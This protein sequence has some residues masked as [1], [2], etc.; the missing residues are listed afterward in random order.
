MPNNALNPS[1]QKNS[2]VPSNATDEQP[3]PTTKGPASQ[4]SSV[5]SM[6][7][8][9]IRG[10]SIAQPIAPKPAMEKEMDHFAGEQ[11]SSLPTSDDLTETI[12]NCV[13]ESATFSKD[14]TDFV[15]QISDRDKCATL[16]T[17]ST[18]TE[19]S[20]SLHQ[21]NE[22]LEGPP[23][24]K[25][26]FAENPLTF[27]VEPVPESRQSSITSSISEDSHLT[28]NESDETSVKS[29]PVTDDAQLPNI[30]QDGISPTVSEISLIPTEDVS[31]SE[32]EQLTPFDNARPPMIE[33]DEAPEHRISNTNEELPL[34]Q[35]NSPESQNQDFDMMVDHG[36][37]D[38]ASIDDL[39]FDDFVPR[40]R[41][42]EV[43]EVTQG[44]QISAPGLETP[45]VL[46]PQ[47][48]DQGN[49]DDGSAEADAAALELEDDN[50]ERR[51]GPMMF[52]YDDYGY[53]YCYYPD[54]AF[55]VPH[56]VPEDFGYSNVAEDSPVD[57]IQATQAMNDEGVS[58]DSTE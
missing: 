3:T 54:T 39:F 35:S 52:L 10:S 2:H 37:I 50:I 47:A 34:L 46:S 25:G 32:H 33:A 21:S 40:V 41:V 28:S 18:T 49:T 43:S 1:S 12:A 36:D 19:L 13:K 27:N 57:E 23:K 15:P 26:S 48:D 56:P 5:H 53:P 30:R 16:S 9:S 8:V 58:R 44:D 7:H 24:L 4:D 45:G 11:A 42:P 38:P 20:A 17:K 14:M 55:C 51:H 22:A 31:T 6:S 29:D